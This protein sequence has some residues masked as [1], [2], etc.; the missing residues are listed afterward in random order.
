[1]FFK[2]LK[3]YISYEGLQRLE[4]FLFPRPALREA[5]LNA[6]VHKDYSSGVPIQISVYDDKIV[7]WS[8]GQLPQ[9]WT[10]ERLLGKHPS[11]PY[12][13]LLANAFFRAGYIESWGRGIEKINRECREHDIAPPLYDYG[14][15]GLMLTF[16]ANPEHL[17]AARGEQENK[18]HRGD[19]PQKT[20]V[21]TSV[22]TPEKILRLLAA[23]PSMTLAEVAAEIKKSLRAVE[24]GSSKLVKEGRLRYVGPQKGGHWEVLGGTDA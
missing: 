10:I 3:A 16:M 22:K 14:M 4:E 23:N 13:P 8:S 18:Q 11:A 6:V 12:N 17:R 20:S 7:L 1:M 19:A 5:L 15:S 2:Y 9:D 24:L 21:K